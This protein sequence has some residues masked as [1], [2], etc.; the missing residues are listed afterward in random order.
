[1]SPQPDDGSSPVLG[2][3]AEPE[4][5]PVTGFSL[6]RE[7]ADALAEGRLDERGERELSEQ[8][9]RVLP[10]HATLPDPAVAT[11]GKVRSHFGGD[12]GLLDWLERHPGRPRLVA[13]LYR[14]IAQ[15]DG[16]SGRPAVVAAV[17]ELREQA[18]DP[19]ELTGFLTP[20]TTSATLAGL[21]TAIERLLGEERVMA[22]VRVA[23]AAAALVR[24]A[25]LQASDHD[26]TLMSLPRRMDVTARQIATAV[27]EW[28]EQRED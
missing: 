4:G 26:A 8:V 13:R 24:L 21:A 23:L 3:T 9:A 17:R 15:L 19:G 16:L 14:L 12:S 10:F 22:A 20:D 1:M 5:G 28:S 25:A 27:D 7:L 2:D 18:G 11:L 6:D